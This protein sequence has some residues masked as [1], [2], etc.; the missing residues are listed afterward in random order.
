MKY[1]Y[2]SILLNF[3]SK[4]SFRLKRLV[5]VT[6]LHY[7]QHIFVEKLLAVISFKHASVSW[8]WSFIQILPIVPLLRVSIKMST[9]F[10]WSHPLYHKHMYCLKTPLTVIITLENVILTTFFWFLRGFSFSNILIL[11]KYDSFQ[12]SSLS[13]TETEARHNL[14]LLKS[15]K[16]EDLLS[17]V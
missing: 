5:L 3:L 2:F 7:S 16:S 11:S 14:K 6:V 1:F 13:V 4:S 12:L 10:I 8:S 9:E 15:L 17:M